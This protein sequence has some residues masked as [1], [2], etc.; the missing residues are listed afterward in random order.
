MKKITI[1]FIP[2]EQQRLKAVGDWQFL[3]NGD[4]LIQISESEDWRYNF[5]FA[6]HEMDEA[7]LCKHRGI[8]TEMVDA[9]QLNP[10]EDDDPDS[11]S[12]YGDAVVQDSHNDA[13]AAEW[14]MSRLLNVDWKE[15]GKAFEKIGNINTSI[16]DAKE[17]GE[18]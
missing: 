16:E 10:S 3:P 15:Y 8:T 18:K 7:I 4:L 17:L 13:L 11:F 1:E 2:H 12:G 6:R 9:D 5:L 14:I